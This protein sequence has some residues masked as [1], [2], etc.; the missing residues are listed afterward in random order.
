[1]IENFVKL[2]NTLKSAQ[3]D[4]NSKI[5]CPDKETFVQKRQ[6]RFKTAQSSPKKT[7]KNAKIDEGRFL[8]RL[9]SNTISISKR[10]EGLGSV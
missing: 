1:M 8:T 7:S 2:I 10:L 5:F 3:E 4:A 6:K 9:I